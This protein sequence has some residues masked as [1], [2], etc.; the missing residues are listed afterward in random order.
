MSVE[1]SAVSR[2]WFRALAE[3]SRDIVLVR[4]VHGVL[5]Y[6]SPTVWAS[7]G[8]RPED[9]QGTHERELI[10]PV[11]LQVRD[12]LIAKLLETNVAQPPAEL[13][14]RTKSG[15]WRWFETI[16]TNCLDNPS[17]RG[18]V[19]NARD[20][21]ERK[22]AEIQLIELSLHDGLTGLANR[23][24]VMDRLALALAR[25]ARTNGVLALLFCDLDEFKVVND[26]VGH[27]GGDRALIEIARRFTGALRDGDTV[28]RIGGDEFVIVCEGL[29]GVDHATALAAHIRDVVEQPIAFDDFEAAVSVSIGIVTVAGAEARAADPMTLLHNADAAM[30]RAKREGKARWA[31][32]D[33]SLMSAASHRRELET[34]LRRALDGNEFVLHY[35]PIYDLNDYTVVG[36]EALLRWNNPTRGLLPPDEFIGLAEETGLIVP[37]GLWV[38]KEACDQ[39]REW[40]QDLRWPGWISVNLSARQLAEPGLAS[41]V[42]EILTA[43]GLDAA[44]LRLELTETALLRAGHSAAVE[45]I[46]V[47]HL[48]VHIGMDDFGTGYAS[49]TNLQRLP[50]DFLKIDRSFVTTLKRGRNRRDHGNAIV[51]AIAQIGQTLDLETIAEGIE[52]EE[53]AELLREYGCP[54]GQGHQFARPAPAKDIGLLLTSPDRSDRVPTVQ[55]HRGAAAPARHVRR[56]TPDIGSHRSNRRHG[57]KNS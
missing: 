21:T 24:L 28:A 35:Q 22:A 12:G 3:S 36:V 16:D 34:E 29:H 54:Y 7:L 1:T 33:E 49:L 47:R 5:S 9:L 53:Q 57:H 20:V 48:G 43:S 26:S 14:I 39:M 23:S 51:A 2:E 46:A 42:R 40:V 18:I 55:Q 45:L 10:H 11:D 31:L 4:D 52:D 17:V 13:R 50:I 15:V 38:L 25:T 41:A 27:A 56:A 37:I 8:Y 32:F 19:T 6:C 44:L 30:Y